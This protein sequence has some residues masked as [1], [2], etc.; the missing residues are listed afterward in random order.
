M[1]H[2]IPREWLLATNKIE[3]SFVGTN[4]NTKRLHGSG[5]WVMTETNEPVFVTNRHVVDPAYY[6]P[7]YIPEKFEI[8]EI[9]VQFCTTTTSFVGSVGQAT[10]WLPSDLDIDIA[11]LRNVTWSEKVAGA[12]AP[13]GLSMIANADYFRTELD[14]GDQVSFASYQYW[15][16]T[17]NGHPILRTGIVSSDPRR[18]YEFGDLRRRGVL[19]LE[20]FSFAGS[21]GSPVFANA[22]GV[23][24]DPTMFSGGNFR[25]AKLIGV[26][27]GHHKVRDSSAGG[28]F[29][30]HSGLS[31]C[32]KSDLLLELLTDLGSSEAQEFEQ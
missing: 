27:A 25:A 19:L 4:T 18:N 20:A 32:H 17:A 31:Y 21:S 2:P 6:D 15:R 24:V 3:V 12:V 22:K 26:M 10:V 5:F 28:L 7:K 1:Y 29:D 11:I 14:W 30:E 23:L 13:V 9:A 16:D 8:A